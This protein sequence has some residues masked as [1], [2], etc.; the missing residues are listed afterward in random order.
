VLALL[1][2]FAVLVLAALDY[3][4]LET[5]WIALDEQTV[6]SPRLPDG[7]NGAKIAFI[8]D[9][10]ADNAAD[11]ALMAEQVQKINAFSPDLVLLGGDFA[12]S[13]DAQCAIF[14]V[15]RN[16]RASIGVYAVR[17]NHDVVA[18]GDRFWNIVSAAGITPLQNQSICLERNGSHIALAGVD[19]FEHHLSYPADALRDVSSDAFC[20]FLAHEPNSVI[21]AKKQGL[22]AQVDRAFV[23]HTHGG[24]VTVFGLLS[25]WAERLFPGVGSKWIRIGSTPTLYSNGLGQKYDLRF[26]ARPQIHLI[27]LVGTPAKR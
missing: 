15:L 12:D 2:A 1:A 22:L 20:L 17:G 9:L 27:T 13:E 24:Q 10:H 6:S 5:L 19:D 26:F 11:F 18:C 8:S 4:R 25:P 23:G 16:L 14:A 21:Q 7:F 3:A